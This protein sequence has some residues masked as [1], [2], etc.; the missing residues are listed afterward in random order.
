[1]IDTNIGIDKEKKMAD[2][3]VGK[4]ADIDTHLSLVNLLEE[5]NKVVPDLLFKPSEFNTWSVDKTRYPKGICQSYFVY[6]KSDIN[7]HIG[8]LEV[9][10]YGQDKPKYGINS[11]NI[12]DGRNTYG[13]DGQFKSSI[14]LKNIIKVAKKVFKPFTFDQIASRCSR[15]FRSSVDSIRSNT[16]WQTRHATC[17]EIELFKDDLENLYHMGYKPKNPK[18]SSFMEYIVQNKERLDKYL[19]YD[20]DHY[21]V[22]IQDDQVQ[23]RLNKDKE[24][25]TVKSKDELPEDIK[26]K[27]FVLDITDKQDFVE[28]VGLKENEGAYWII[29]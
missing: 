26:G 8:K 19:G 11:I 1:M 14:H 10:D 21:F 23:Y 6:H 3:K 5:V 4:Y 27:L 16:H 22:L 18:I 9:S 20:P 17:S 24:P 28:D 25:I 15:S 29:A 12:T 2:Y 13:I 7:N